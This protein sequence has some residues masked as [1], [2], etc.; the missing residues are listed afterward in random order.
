MSNLWEQFTSKKHQF[1]A[2]VFPRFDDWNLTGH[3]RF[4]KPILVQ[5]NLDI[6]K[7]QT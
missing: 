6:T 2:N 5:W 1:W 7:D 3:Q 4:E